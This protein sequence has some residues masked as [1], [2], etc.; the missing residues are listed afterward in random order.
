MIKTSINPLSLVNSVHK[1]EH[2]A[3]NVEKKSAPVS[4]KLISQSNQIMI[5]VS[6]NDY[7]EN[8]LREL[9]KKVQKKPYSKRIDEHGTYW[10]RDTKN[11]LMVVVY[12]KGSKISGLK[13]PLIVIGILGNDRSQDVYIGVK[14]NGKLSF[15]NSIQLVESGKFEFTGQLKFPNKI[16]CKEAVVS[17]PNG[18]AEF[19]ESFLANIKARSDSTQG[20]ET[21][22]K[23]GTGKV[24][25]TP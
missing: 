17:L 14:K 11:K 15:G 19:L 18:N 8:I 9:E 4:S 7:E 10:L 16:S 24:F 1:G 12:P 5:R 21:K 3:F 25:A 23:F 20:I 13:F 22:K 6:S 2:I